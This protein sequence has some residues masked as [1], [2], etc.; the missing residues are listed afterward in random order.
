MQAKLKLQVWPPP[1][2]LLEFE[3]SHNTMDSQVL[4]IPLE[5]MPVQGT[6]LAFRVTAEVLANDSVTMPTA[7]VLKVPASVSRHGGLRVFVEDAAGVQHPLYAVVLDAG[8]RPEPAEGQV[9][10]AEPDL[11]PLRWMLSGISSITKAIG[12]CQD[13]EVIIERFAPV[14]LFPLLQCIMLCRWLLIVRLEPAEGRQHICLLVPSKGLVCR[15]GNK[16]VTYRVP[17]E[18]LPPVSEQW[19]FPLRPGNTAN[20][21]LL[22][23]RSQSCLKTVHHSGTC[24][25]IKGSKRKDRGSSKEGQGSAKRR[26]EAKHNLSK[27]PVLAGPDGAPCILP[28]GVASTWAQTSAHPQVSWALCHGERVDQWP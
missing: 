27:T 4:P 26:S 22:C 17:V 11:G 15:Q 10:Q 18:Q 28:F 7:S 3:G 6:F 1:R 5:L 16:L 14:C 2:N 19:A 24:S 20:D 8:V 21:A 23:Q 9:E 25:T 12:C 13:D